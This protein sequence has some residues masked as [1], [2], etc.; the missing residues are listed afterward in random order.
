MF[1]VS[2][3]Y[4]NYRPSDTS[5]AKKKS[6]PRIIIY[7]QYEW[8][9]NDEEL[10]NKLFVHLLQYIFHACSSHIVAFLL[11]YCGRIKASDWN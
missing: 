4:N 9:E 5:G 7:P 10:A 6:G 2:P 8:V 3:K 11:K 1:N